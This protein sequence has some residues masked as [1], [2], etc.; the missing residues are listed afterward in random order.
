MTS[1]VIDD[2]RRSQILELLDQGKRIDGR[3]LDESRKLTVEVDAIPKANGSARS[4]RLNF[5]S[6]YYLSIT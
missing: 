4:I 3:A 6:T 1:T 2:L 5:Y